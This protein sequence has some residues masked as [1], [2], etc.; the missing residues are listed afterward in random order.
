MGVMVI[1]FVI[2][3][4]PTWHFIDPILSIVFSFVAM[5]MCSTYPL[6]KSCIKMIMEA[7]PETTNV[8][9]LK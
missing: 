1:S 7:S 2:Y 8:P 3:F 5:F 4:E 6:A 9:N